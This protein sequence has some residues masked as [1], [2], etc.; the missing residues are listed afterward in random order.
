MRFGWARVGAACAVSTMLAACASHTSSA[1]PAKVPNGAWHVASGAVFS[2]EAPPA[3]PASF[4]APL[5]VSIDPTT[6]RLALPLDPS[7]QA[8]LGEGLS[9]AQPSTRRALIEEG[10]VVL[11]V[12]PGPLR[13][14][15]LYRDVD[16]RGAPA[17]FTLDAAAELAHIAL[18]AAL[19]EARETVVHDA[20]LGYVEGAELALRKAGENPHADLLVPY[21]MA[22]AIIG[23]AHALLDKSYDPPPESAVKIELERRLI[24]RAESRQPSPI[25]GIEIDYRAFR[26][27]ANHTDAKSIATERALAWLGTAPFALAGRETAFGTDLDVSTVRTHTRAALLLA[28][29]SLAGDARL[30]PH[31]EPSAHEAALAWERLWRLQTFLVGEPDDLVPGDLLESATAAHVDVRNDLELCDVARVDRIRLDAARRH[32]PHIVDAVGPYR[33]ASALPDHPTPARILHSVRILGAPRT[34]DSVVL[35]RLSGAAVGKRI[36]T[37]TDR[38]GV[39]RD[40]PSALDFALWLG[41]ADARRAL[42]ATAADDYTNYDD[43]MTSLFSLRPPELDRARHETVYLSYL[44]ALAT[45]A[46]PSQ[47]SA[48]EASVRQRFGAHRLTRTLAIWTTLRHDLASHTIVR[49]PPTRQAEFDRSPPPQ[50]V[51][52]EAHPEALSRWVSLVR[53]VRDGMLATRAIGRSGPAKAVLDDVDALL[54]SAFEIALLAAHDTAPSDEQRAKVGRLADRMAALEASV[55]SRVPRRVPVHLA[56]RSDRQLVETVGALK[57]QAQVV[58]VPG[59]GKP[60]LA[61]G[62]ALTHEESVERA[63]GL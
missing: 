18:A 53:Q 24:E 14:S 36:G 31:Q 62:P 29:V 33:P 35:A 9:H 20:V 34:L 2:V 1:P 44:D 58:R 50:H 3:D 49:A 30:S 23:T 6:P 16:R 12:Q 43:V 10:A 21:R 28:R 42:G 55:D 46:A 7:I 19:A 27:H 56:R 48:A 37:P 40:V 52:V 13:V 59:A 17:L 38:F 57:L 47:A 25:T 61:Y 60:L 11:G 32:P 26:L 15:E 45:Q 4:W 22:G 54:T 41:S 51:F 8:A 39:T 5:T 63:S